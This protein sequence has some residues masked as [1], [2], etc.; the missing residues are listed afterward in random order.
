VYET[1]ATERVTLGQL[2]KALDASIRTHE[3][4]PLSM[5]A[6]ASLSLCYQLVGGEEEAL[7]VLIKLRDIDLKPAEVYLWLSLYYISRRDIESAQEALDTGTNLD[8]EHKFLRVCQG[9]LYALEGKKGEAER[10]SQTLSSN[11]NES[12]R[13]FAQL[14][15]QT[16]LGNFAEAFEAL[17][18]MAEKHCWPY[19]VTLHP[20]Y[21]DLRRDSRFG[22]FCR[23]VGITTSRKGE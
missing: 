10:E 15:I 16:A 5:R 21:K 13:L 2:H 22:D 4:D 6:A 20:F 1:L 8:P 18:R 19:H 17:R 7:D 9:A 12:V 3:L 14:L 23:K 11:E